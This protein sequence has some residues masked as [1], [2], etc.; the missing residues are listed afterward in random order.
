MGVD[1][2]RWV[3]RA[4]QDQAFRAET[5]GFMLAETEED[6]EKGNRINKIGWRE[7]VAK[8]LVKREVEV[9]RYGGGRTF[10]CKALS[11]FRTS[12]DL[13]SIN[14][15]LMLLGILHI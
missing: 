8:G 13:S 3:G 2:R 7:C 15:N 10:T 14:I 4:Y 5:T 1:C 12:P 11:R 6:P 9:S